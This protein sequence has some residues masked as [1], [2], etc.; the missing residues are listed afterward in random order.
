MTYYSRLYTSIFISLFFFTS[1]VAAQNWRQLGTSQGK[2]LGEIA[3]QNRYG[4]GPKLFDGNGKYRGEVSNNR[5]DPNSISNP[6]GKYG[7]KYSPDSINNP[8]G[9]GSKYKSGGINNPYSVP[10]GYLGR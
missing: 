9:A 3:E 5:Y 6:Y 8:Y 10:R 1:T 2:S 7:S 4:S